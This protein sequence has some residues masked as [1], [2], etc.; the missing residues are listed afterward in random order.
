MA[1]ITFSTGG[2]RTRGGRGGGEVQGVSSGRVESATGRGEASSSRRHSGRLP[3]QAYTVPETLA[4]LDTRVTPGGRRVFV[5]LGD[6]PPE[7]YLVTTTSWSTI[8]TRTSSSLGQTWAGRQGHPRGHARRSTRVTCPRRRLI[9]MAAGMT[10]MDTSMIVAVQASATGGPSRPPHSIRFDWAMAILSVLF[11]GGL[12]LDGWA[13][14]HGRVDQSFFTPWHAVF[15]AGYAAVASVLVVSLLRNYARGYAW[16]LALPAGYGLSLL[17]ALIF[18]VG[19][20]TDL[21]WHTLFGI[22]AGVEA[23]LSPTHLALALGLG[24]IAS[25]PVRAAWQRP[26]PMSGWS[27]QGP[28]LLAFTSTLS[29]FTFFTEYAHPVVYAAA[30]AGHPHGG[31]EGPG[32]SSILLQTGGAHGDNPARRSLWEAA[33]GSVHVDRHAECRG[34]GVS[35]F[36]RRLPV[37]VG[38]GCRGSR[39][40]DR[41]IVCSSVPDHYASCCL[42]PVRLRCPGHLL[43]LLFPC[44]AVV[45]RYRLVRSPLGRIDHARRYRRLVAQLPPPAAPLIG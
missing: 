18:A 3:R 35:Q 13:H 36:F 26:R 31:A 17:G 22:E 2:R 45:R 43:P 5:A 28:M 1:T 41:R 20:V 4:S 40:D 39:A 34:H 38:G 33:P 44:A 10:P 14:T 24:L 9:Y 12:F 23:L 21:I 37:G 30:G 7:D 11:V 15:Y 8:A 6:R 32:V 29:V 19:G 27:V 42:A 25:G 16:R